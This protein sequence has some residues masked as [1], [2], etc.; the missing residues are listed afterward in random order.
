MNDIRKKLQEELH[1]LEYELRNEL[2]REIL[3]AREHG[4][5]SENAEYHAAKER[6]GLVNAKMNKLKQRL[7]EL[8]MID[9]TKIPHD[10]V[11]LGSKVKVLDVVKDEE[12]TYELVMSEDADAVKNM[13]STSSPI[14]RALLGKEVGDSVKV[15]SPGGLKELEI[16]KLVTVHDAAAEP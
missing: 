6:Q 10:R 7:S 14:G 5:L 2:P 13:I 11:G 12:I 1:A 15:T 4:D 9:F 16:V 8:A 3:T